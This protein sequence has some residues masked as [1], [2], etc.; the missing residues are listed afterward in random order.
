MRQ[1]H[2]WFLVSLAASSMASLPACSGAS[3]TDLETGSADH[4][5]PQLAGS[6]DFEGGNKGG[7]GAADVSLTSGTW[8]LDDALIGA[9]DTDVKDGAHAARIRN[10]GNVTMG[11]DRTGAGTVSVKSASF[12]TDANGSWG[13]FYSLDQGGTWSQVGDAVT[14]SPSTLATATF[15]V[16]QAGNVRLQIRKLDGGTNRIDVDDITIGDYDGGGGGGDTDGGTG[17][18]SGGGGGGGGGGTAGASVSVHTTLGLPSAASTSDVNDY[19]SVKSEY[20]LSYNSGRKIPNWV[21]WELN[22]GY[23]G[24]IDRSDDF[25]ADDTFPSGMAQAA[26]GD[27]S[28]SGYDRGHMC[29][30]G[31]RTATKTA[32]Q[33]TFYLTNMVPQAGNNNRGPWERFET[34]SR[35]LV[36]S[37]KELFVTS[38][39]VVTSG[40][41]T[42][43]AGVVVP[44]STFKVVTVLD[45]TGQGAA[46]VTASTRVIAIV[47]PNDD[48]QVSMSADWHT[49]RVS[50]RSIESA[51]NLNFLSDVDQGVQD[52]VE[53]QVDNQD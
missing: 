36:S 12:G 11:F 6:E 31:D 41:K 22:S 10:S 47:V 40:S 34:Y 30:S 27:Y 33:Q 35:T 14:T 23:I 39:S 2:V 8:N 51:T 28:G 43:G 52:T 45:H 32:N 21:S 4:L 13:L 46:D 42:I 18:D 25:R 1:N 29:P 26:L 16:N 17:T 48:S 53:N 37:G 49:F 5:S 24:S 3:H 50:A 7:Y 19:L 9:L 15:T 20:V 38:G 44:D